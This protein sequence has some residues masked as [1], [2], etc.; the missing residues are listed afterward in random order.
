MQQML[1]FA[2]QQNAFPLTSVGRPV[3]SPGPIDAYPGFQGIAAGP[4]GPG[5][6]IANGFGGNQLAQYGQ[7]NALTDGALTPPA[8]TQAFINATP[9]GLGGLGT[10]NLATLAPCH[11]PSRGTSSERLCCARRR[12]AIGSRRRRCGRRSRPIR[13][14]RRPWKIEW[15]PPFRSGSRAPVRPPARTPRPARP[16][17]P[18]PPVGDQ[19]PR[20]RRAHKQ[21]SNSSET[22][23]RAR[24]SASARRTRACGGGLQAV[25]PRGHGRT[26]GLVCRRGALPSDDGVT[27]PTP[28]LTARPA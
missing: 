25:P 8:V 18:A 17:R 26:A 4:G 1:W 22:L 19:P 7:L 13:W 24:R 28:V 23:T 10:A 11:R 21:L 2:N 9:G 12:W 20:A 6:A 27:Q 3:L 14:P 16:W 15:S 5:W